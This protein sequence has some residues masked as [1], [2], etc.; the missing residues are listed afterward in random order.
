MLSLAGNALVLWWSVVFMLQ[1]S[2]CDSCNMQTSIC[3][4]DLSCFHAG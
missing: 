4:A 3:H 2:P 1:V